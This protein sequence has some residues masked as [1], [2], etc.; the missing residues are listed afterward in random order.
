MKKSVWD[1]S[2][3][4]ERIVEKYFNSKFDHTGTIFDRAVIQKDMFY[5]V[6]YLLLHMYGSDGSLDFINKYTIYKRV[7]M[8]KISNYE[9]IFEEFKSLLIK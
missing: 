7:N 5:D 4:L 6:M 2:Y 1:I 8:E 3:E 9:K